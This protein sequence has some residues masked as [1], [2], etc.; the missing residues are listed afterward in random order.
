MVVCIGMLPEKKIFEQVVNCGIP[1][2]KIGDC[3]E[4]RN[5]MSA[6]WDGYRKLRV[7]D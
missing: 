5:V 3:Y 6:V 4:P 2:I 7:I 1:F